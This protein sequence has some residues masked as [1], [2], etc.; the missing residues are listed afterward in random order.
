M[1][2]CGAPSC[3]RRLLCAVTAAPAC[4]RFPGRELPSPMLTARQPDE[5]SVSSNSPRAP[6]TAQHHLEGAIVSHSAAPY[7]FIQRLMHNF[8]VFPVRH[9]IRLTT[10]P[11]TV[12][13]EVT[14]HRFVGDELP[15]RL[16]HLCVEAERF[17]LLHRN[18]IQIKSSVFISC[19]S[20]GRPRC[21]SLIRRRCAT[22]AVTSGRS[23]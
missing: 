14:E 3:A 7:R 20:S 12:S 16:H 6:L 11:E 22:I 10:Y 9:T 2:P 17:K 18:T 5:L 4:Q 21:S 13:T 15:G 19:S 23:R 8:L 1:L